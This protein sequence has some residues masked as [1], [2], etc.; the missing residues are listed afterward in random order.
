MYVRLLGW[1]LEVVVFAL[2]LMMV[3]RYLFRLLHGME[4][5]VY[6]H[7]LRESAAATC[8]VIITDFPTQQWCQCIFHIGTASAVSL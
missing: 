6:S 5:L 2:H 8:M 1:L 7:Y 4:A 3:C